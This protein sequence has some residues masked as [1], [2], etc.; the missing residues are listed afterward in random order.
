MAWHIQKQ[1]NWMYL[2]EA[3]KGQMKRDLGDKRPMKYRCMTSEALYTIWIF[4]LK[5][6]SENRKWNQNIM[7]NVENEISM[8]AEWNKFPLAMEWIVVRVLCL[9]V[10]T[11]RT[12]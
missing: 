8:R 2:F 11:L 1:A 4:K 9:C 3:K 12:R 7:H 6:N 5:N 10:H